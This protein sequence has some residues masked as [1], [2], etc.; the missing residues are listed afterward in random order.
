[1][2]CQHESGY[3]HLQLIGSYTYKGLTFHLTKFCKK[4]EWQ[5]KTHGCCNICFVHL[6]EW[7]KFPFK[8]LCWYS[9]LHFRTVRKPKLHELF[10][11]PAR[12]FVF[13]PVSIWWEGLSMGFWNGNHQSCCIQLDDSEDYLAMNCS[14]VDI[15]IQDH[16]L[17]TWGQNRFFYLALSGASN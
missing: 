9:T 13:S 16:L 14:K 10:P 15:A 3:C 8:Y 17:G 2:P 6:F 12:G 7:L 5:G 11:F 4:I 1:M